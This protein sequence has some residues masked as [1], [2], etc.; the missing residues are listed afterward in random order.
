MEII[1]I[2]ILVPLIFTIS[3]VAIIYIFLKEPK[4]ITK[5]FFS[6]FGGNILKEFLGIL[7]IPFL[8]AL[9]IYLILFKG[10]RLKKEDYQKDLLEKNEEESEEG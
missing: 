5:D 8:P 4:Q 1:L 6:Y 3:I 2:K 7:L 9:V 10:G